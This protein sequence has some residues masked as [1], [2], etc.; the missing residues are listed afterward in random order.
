MVKVSIDRICQACKA[1]IPS[2]IVYFW[3]DGSFISTE[4]WEFDKDFRG[5]VELL[6]PPVHVRVEE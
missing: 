2:K 3:D 1:R 4:H 5:L 6:G